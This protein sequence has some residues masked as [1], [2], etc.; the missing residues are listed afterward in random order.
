MGGDE[1]K[2]LRLWREKR[3][4]IEPENLDDVL[5][6]Q[7][8][9]WTEP[10]NAAWFERVTGKRVVSRGDTRVSMDHPW[11]RCNLDGEVSHDGMI[12]V[13][14]AKHVSAFAKEDEIVRRYHWQL[15]H[16]MLV[17]GVTKAYLSVFFGTLKHVVFEVDADPLSQ[18]Q[19]VAAERAFWACVETGEPPVAIN[20]QAPVEAVKRVDMTGSNSWA[21]H[22]DKWIATK[23]Y[24]KTFETATKAL[25]EL[26]EADV[27]EAFGHGITV[28]RNKAGNLS[29]SESK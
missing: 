15:Q 16:C 2:I 3:G 19:L 8:G 17:T 21:E 26:V 22:A 6:V 7:M 1:E 14:E 20:V 4:E 27:V 25:K 12:S 24:A 23:G 28:K 5:P 10:F 11:M 9:V 13:W 29:I 18:A